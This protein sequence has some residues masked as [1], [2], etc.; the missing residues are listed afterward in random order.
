MTGPRPPLGVLVLDDGTVYGVARD[1]VLG[2][3]PENA[4]EVLTG[5]ADALPLDDPD[6]T[7]SRVHAKLQLVDWTVELVDAGS[8][9]GTF[10]AA[11]GQTEWTRLPA[12][13][14]VALTPGTKISLGGRTLVF[15]SHHKL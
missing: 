12:N 5:Q 7:M 10:T 9:N 6:V 14:R 2:R 1:Y 13:G 3:E 8:A 4:P 11:P 15:D